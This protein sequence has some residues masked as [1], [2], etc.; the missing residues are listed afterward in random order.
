MASVT[1]W[2]NLV[3]FPAM[4]D[5]GPAISSYARYSKRKLSGNMDK[6]FIRMEKVGGL[7]EKLD[8][9]IILEKGDMT[10]LEVTAALTIIHAHAISVCAKDTKEAEEI[11][12]YL[13]KRILRPL[14]AE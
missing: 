1:Y 7:V 12:N 9:C 2:E 14:E 6:L 10:R 4:A 3:A 5:P 13:E 8:D 11:F